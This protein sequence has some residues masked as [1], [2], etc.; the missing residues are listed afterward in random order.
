MIS[1]NDLIGTTKIDLETRWLSSKRGNAGLARSYVPRGVN[2]WRDALKPSEILADWC[3][4]HGFPPPT[5]AVGDDDATV[6]I[7]GFNDSVPFVAVEPEP[8]TSD[9][10][11]KD[12]EYDEVMK[13]NA[14][15]VALHGAG[16]VETRPLFDPAQPDLE[17]GKLQL[18]VDM[19]LKTPGVPYPLPVDISPRKPKGY[20]LRVGV[21]D[22]AAQV[23]RL[24]TQLAALHQAH[25]ELGE[26]L[27]RV[28]Q[29]PRSDADVERARMTAAA[30][31]EVVL[32][33]HDELL[34]SAEHLRAVADL[35]PVLDRLDVPA[36][37]QQRG[38]FEPLHV[39][40]AEQGR[41][42]GELL[43]RGQN[44]FETYN[45]NALA[46]SALFVEWHALLGELEQ[47]LDRLEREA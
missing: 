6:T 27:R 12:E 13:E 7:E 10:A 31:A 1:A 20:V 24:Q 34:Q 37:I 25:P 17:Q 29:L 22:L 15:L 16:L 43:A 45:D 18:W 39:V 4:K 42:A 44:V 32:A 26:L 3:S 41:V 35:Q 38:P 23:A 40:H 2:R 5:Y 8:Q 11:I 33:V 9:D 28:D 19:F 14:A 30:K 47:R 36:V 21:G 46:L